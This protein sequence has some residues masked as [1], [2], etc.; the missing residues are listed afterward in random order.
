[1]S[2]TDY[3]ALLGVD[4][5]STPEEIGQSFRRLARQYHPDLH[6]EDAEAE[7]RFREISEAYQTLSDPERRAR[8]DMEL[9]SSQ[10]G[11]GQVSVQR[12]PAEEG[13]V[14]F[15]EQSVVI[16]SEDLKEAINELRGVLGEGATVIADQLRGV[17][18]DFATELDQITRK[19]Q[20]GQTHHYR[21][22][23]FPPNGGRP[24]GGGRPPKR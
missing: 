12:G 5:S 7:T 9:M 19:A 13:P 3:Y 16:D 10:S 18:N 11:Q 22:H 1:M 14:V 23:G 21:R 17:L 8:Y 20:S 6:P 24:P 2:H 15:H 4:R